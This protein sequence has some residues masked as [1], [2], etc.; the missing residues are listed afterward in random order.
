MRLLPDA[1]LLALVL[2]AV[3][4]IAL[5][6]RRMSLPDIAGLLLPGAALTLALRFALTAAGFIPI[7]LSLVAALIA[8]LFD[9]L[10][11]LRHAT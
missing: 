4:L 10:R 8:H 9:L 7:A 3:L 6:R 11:R 1:V 2:E 5:A